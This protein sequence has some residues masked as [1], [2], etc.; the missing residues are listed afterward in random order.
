MCGSWVLQG[1]TALFLEAPWKDIYG[2]FKKGNLFPITYSGSAYRC[3]RMYVTFVDL[4]KNTCVGCMWERI[5]LFAYLCAFIVCTL[6]FLRMQLVPKQH[7]NIY[8]LMSGSGI[9]A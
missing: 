3:G 7:I 1:S 2:G 6:C 9:D 4:V 5:V 8:L